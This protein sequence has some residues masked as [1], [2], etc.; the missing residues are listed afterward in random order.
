MAFIKGF[1]KFNDVLLKIEEHA[2]N[3]F[4][5]FLIAAIMIQVIC[6]YILKFPT[7]WAEEL[8]RY[9]FIWL[10]WIGGAYAINSGAHVEI[11][12]L[13]SLAPKLFKNAERALWIIGKISSALIITFLTILLIHYID[14][15]KQLVKS[16]AFLTATKISVGY[17]ASSVLVGAVLGILHSLYLLVKPF[18][19]KENDKESEVTANE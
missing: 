2:M 14:Y 1:K 3:F 10:C 4:M 16:G 18:E 7:P 15:F 12:L 19:P 5:I 11:N 8:A 17:T 6:R 13:D 9:V